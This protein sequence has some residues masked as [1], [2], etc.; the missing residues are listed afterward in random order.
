MMKPGADGIVA[1]THGRIVERSGA[2]IVPLDADLEDWCPP[3]AGYFL[4]EPAAA[5]RGALSADRHAS[6][7]L[8]NPS[9]MTIGSKHATS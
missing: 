5:A 8:P 6:P 7:G 1:D 2:T 3:F 4:S 9:A